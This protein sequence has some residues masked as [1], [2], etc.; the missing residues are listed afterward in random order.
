MNYVWYKVASN[1]IS[2]I[3]VLVFFEGVFKTLIILEFLISFEP[4]SSNGLDFNI[5]MI[6][7]N[8]EIWILA[9]DEFVHH[10]KW[11]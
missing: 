8:L 5:Q 7:Q 6:E 9:C 10:Q 3:H 1:F 4:Q 11:R 2:Y